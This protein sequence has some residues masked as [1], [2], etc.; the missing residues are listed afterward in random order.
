MQITQIGITVLTV[1]AMIEYLPAGYLCSY[2]GWCTRKKANRKQA[3]AF[4]LL[5]NAK[6]CQYFQSV[7][8]AI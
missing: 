6:L 4:L 3:Q 7:T 8:F 1:Q 5:E 2:E